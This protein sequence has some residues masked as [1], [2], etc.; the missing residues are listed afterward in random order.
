MPVV[1]SKKTKTAP[2]VK[3]SRLKHESKG[4]YGLCI[5]CNYAAECVTARNSS[6]P[7]IFCEMFDDYIEPA[8][9]EKPKLQ[10]K[11]VPVEKDVNELK[12]LCVN[13]EERHTCKFPKPEGGIWHCE[14][15]R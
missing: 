5:T 8:Q 9:A 10:A 2:D 6:E 3:S 4:Y 15:Y 7:V 14:E 13:C 11:S 12:G 1:K